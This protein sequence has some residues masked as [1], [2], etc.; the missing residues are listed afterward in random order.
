MA[1]PKPD[2]AIKVI[3][4]IAAIVIIP[5]VFNAFGVK[6]TPQVVAPVK[7]QAVAPVSD[8]A[9]IKAKVEAALESKPV[10]SVFVSGNVAIITMAVTKEAW[11]GDGGDVVAKDKAQVIASTVHNAVPEITSVRVKDGNEKTLGTFSE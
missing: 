1:A 9:A 7:Q 8:D 5:A 4:I 11:G 10:H 6:S 2:N 3:A